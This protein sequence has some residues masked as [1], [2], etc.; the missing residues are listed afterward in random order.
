MEL[1]KI[2]FEVKSPTIITRR[3]TRRGFAA[4]LNYVPPSMLRGALISSLHSKNIIDNAYLEKEATSPIL[5]TSP[6]YPVDKEGESYPAHPFIY[7]CKIPHGDVTEIYNDGKEVLLRVGEA[8]PPKLRTLCSLGHPALE[9]LHP[10][11]LIPLKN[12]SFKKVELYTQQFT[13]VGISRHRAT[14]FRGMLYE[15]EAIAEG[16]RFWA[17]ISTPE[18]MVNVFKP[19]FEFSIG[20]G[21]SRGFGRA[22]IREIFK[23]DL[24]SESKNFDKVLK[25]GKRVV[26]YA[27]SNLVSIK[28]D[29]TS[30]TYPRELE[31]KPIG[32]RFN[33][34]V[35]GKISIDEVYGRTLTLHTGWD[36]RR[37]MEKPSVRSAS[38][39]SIAIGRITATGEV[40]KTL[41][42]LSRIGTV[43]HGLDFNVT[44]VN[45]MIPLEMHPMVGSE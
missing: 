11:L 15:Y 5:V 6:A 40:S 32:E 7:E 27:L 9:N 41:V 44:G 16:V 18:D 26:F 1:I 34:H 28:V 14:S 19:G 35:D 17:N 10:R 22:V 39:G 13:N 45:V 43:E 37:N 4:P 29:N 23:I 38:H 24:D 31:L 12:G 33:L 25:E 20:R 8:L 2:I 21:I 30:S 3:M 36:I 42:I